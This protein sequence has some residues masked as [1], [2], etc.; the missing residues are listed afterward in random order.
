MQFRQQPVDP[1]GSLACD[2]YLCLSS[3]IR[4]PSNPSLTRPHK[5][6]VQRWG[7]GWSLVGKVS[8]CPGLGAGSNNVLI[9][10]E[11]WPPRG[12]WEPR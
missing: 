2:A 4:S 8:L 11:G 10:T 7:V 1:L 6:Q 5:F 3:R 12:L 9:R